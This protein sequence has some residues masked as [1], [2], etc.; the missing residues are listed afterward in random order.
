MDNLIKGIGKYAVEIIIAALLLI[1]VS[2]IRW[3]LMFFFVEVLVG[4]WYQTDYLRKLIRVFQVANETK[5]MAIANKVGVEKGEIERMLKE[6]E[7]KAGSE[8]WKQVEK[9]FAD[10]AK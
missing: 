10:I 4:S 3:F 9:D 1:Y 5:I 8:N 6:A 7:Q 2:D